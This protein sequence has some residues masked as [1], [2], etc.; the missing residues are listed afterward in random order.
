MT[1]VLIVQPYVPS[2]RV[3]FFDR[4]SLAL[5]ANGVHMRVAAPLPSGA[6]SQR[7]DA[8]ATQPW[9][10]PTKG[11]VFRTP[12]ATFT[13]YGSTGLMP[14]YDAIV[15][16]AAG[17]CL[18][19]HL[20]L[21]RHSRR[22][23]V[24]LWGHIGAY[25]RKPN[26]LDVAIERSQLRRAA[27]I[28]AYTQGGADTAIAA[29]VDPSVITTLANTIDTSSLVQARTTLNP[30]QLEEFRQ[31]YDLQGLTGMYLG[32]LDADK[33]ID[34][35]RDTLDYLWVR[36]PSFRLLVCGR[37]R[38]S[39]LLDASAARGQ[40]YL[41]GR[42][43]DRIKALASAVSNTMINPGRV[44]LVAVDA[45]ALQVP[46]VTTSAAE[47]AP[48]VEYLKEGADIFTSPADP[49]RFGDLIINV[50]ESGARPTSQP[51]SLSAMVDSYSRGL[52]QMIHTHKTNGR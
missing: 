40:A 7:E 41:L 12:L 46:V 38:D 28:F 23:P 49:S 50:S 11:R 32:G 4:L 33:R 18:D 6:Q 35:L 13:H 29:G 22:V 21:A 15:T 47:H 9:L 5:A 37:G 34:L 3:P 25:V 42:A 44:G 43:D 52:L 36:V 16:P 8:A 17:T 51:P 45:L 39:T 27:R 31:M 2:Y 20:A 19:T 26:P 1:S 48:E 30:S 24:G 10:I 14:Q